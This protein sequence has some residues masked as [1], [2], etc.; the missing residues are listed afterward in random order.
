MID[1]WHILCTQNVEKFKNLEI[2]EKTV[3]WQNPQFWVN[4]LKV[5]PCGFAQ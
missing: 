4:L 1:Q 2:K 5:D 3:F